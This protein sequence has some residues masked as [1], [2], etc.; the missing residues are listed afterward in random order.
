MRLIFRLSLILALSAALTLPQP[1][2]RAAFPAID[3]KDG[4][5][6]LAP[7]LRKVTP[8]VVN[9]AVKSRVQ[10][11]QNPL[12][13]DPFFRRFFDLPDVPQERETQSVG[14]GV[15]VDSAKGHILTN[16]H[17]IANA[18]E[19]MVT[20]TDRRRIKATLVG[21]D[22]ATDIALLRLQAEKLVA[23]PL[24]DSDALEVGDFVIAIGNPFGLGQ[25]VTSGIVSA[26]GRGGLT[27]EGYEDFIQTDASINPGNSGGA[28][29]NLKGE[30][31]GINTAI[32]APGGGNVGI[33]FAVPVNMARAVMQ[34]LL[35][36]GEVRRGWLGVS[37]QDLTP[38]IAQAIGVARSEGVVV[39]EVTARSPADKAGVK[40][41]DVI[42]A[43]DGRRVSSARDLRNRI[44][45]APIGT[46]ITLTVIRKNQEKKLTA[47]IDA[48]APVIAPV[49]AMPPGFY[50]AAFR[51]ARSGNGVLVTAVEPGS[52]AWRHGLRE[53]D[54]IFAVN[55]RPARSVEEFMGHTRK[56]D[57]PLALDIRRGGRLILI[58]IP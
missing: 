7:L 58:V 54:I 9:I 40:A 51:D 57:K 21:S 36:F 26:L 32:I 4:I 3:Q 6:T 34:Q 13:M 17:V 25:T 2:A 30:L 42:T 10:I 22:P 43:I 33:G 56:R 18:D 45:L 1:A 15:I 11:P 31:V 48:P 23:V 38:A 28:L 37:I 35:R 27:P 44:G 39:T 55:R 41:S 52:T 46:K 29:I 20:L 12:L 19:I 24:G 50:G 47:T 14:S 8:G 49:E 53:G 16:H 5:P